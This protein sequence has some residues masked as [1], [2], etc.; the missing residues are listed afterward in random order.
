MLNVECSIPDQSE[1]S[2][3][4]IHHS[5]LRSLPLRCYPTMQIFSG[6]MAAVASP[7]CLVHLVCFVHLVGF[8]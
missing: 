3:L 4:L 8:V 5:T 7:V 6:A 1:N 2:T